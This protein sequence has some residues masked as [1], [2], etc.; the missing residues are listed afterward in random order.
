MKKNYEFLAID[1]GKQH[2]LR[3]DTKSEKIQWIKSLADYPTARALQRVD[4]NRVLMGYNNGYCIFEI[5]TGN[6]IKDCNQWTNVTSAYR[7]SDGT[8]LIT[9]LNL[10]DQR[11]VCVITLD[12]NDNVIRTESCEGDYVRLMTVSEDNYLLSTNDHIKIC[13]S[14]LN[15]LRTLKAEGFLH[16]WQSK[17]CP[18]SSIL[19][20]AGYGSFMA[21][22]S[23]DGKLLSTFGRASDLPPEIV[24][25]F[26]A[27]FCLVPDG[28]ILLA[29]WQG[30][31]EDNGNKG[32]QLI[33]FS[34]D[35][36]YLNSWSFPEVIS[37]FQ[38]LL[39]LS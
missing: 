3:A 37:S 1:E 7:N 4:K 35:G 36:S 24:P 22:F 18:D 14:K 12:Q 30:H 16:A 32:R 19:V 10:E 28:S 27:S 13:D 8:T 5:S 23:K 2:L 11:G 39:I 34:S 26:Y 25:N 6:I 33:Q 17:I 20:S 29:N 31:G 38:G 21:K 15:T 9:G